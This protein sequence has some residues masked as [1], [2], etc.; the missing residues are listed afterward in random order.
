MSTDRGT[1]EEGVVHTYNGILLL[2]LLLSQFSHVLPGSS[3]GGS[4]EF[5]GEMESVRKTYLFRN[6]KRN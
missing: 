3:P 1:D 4:R 6:I 5:E 2:L